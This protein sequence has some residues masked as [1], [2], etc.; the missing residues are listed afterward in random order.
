MPTNKWTSIALILFAIVV[1]LAGTW[2]MTQ[3]GTPL[4][5]PSMKGYA[6]MSQYAWA[7][8]LVQIFM[9]VLFALGIAGVVLLVKQLGSDTLRNLG[10]GETPDS[11]DEILRTRFAKG[12]ITREQFDEM[13][14]A[15]HS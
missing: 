2:L 13:L 6:Y 10:M 5:M 11:P 12:D 15:L 14:H 8:A 7:M 3:N 4:F 1:V 9:V